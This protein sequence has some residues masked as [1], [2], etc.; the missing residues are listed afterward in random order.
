M[1][2]WNDIIARKEGIAAFNGK[3]NETLYEEPKQ[4]GRRVIDWTFPR[5]INKEEVCYIINY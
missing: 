1:K 3:A 5:T 2:S 4:Q